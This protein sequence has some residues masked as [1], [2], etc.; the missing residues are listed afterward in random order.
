[1]AKEGQ[2]HGC[3]HWFDRYVLL[4][5]TH[6]GAAGEI[7]RLRLKLSYKDGFFFSTFVPRLH[8]RQSDQCGHQPLS[9]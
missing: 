6:L 3:S 5:R 1:Y 2:K 9:F 7:H 8:F 4:D